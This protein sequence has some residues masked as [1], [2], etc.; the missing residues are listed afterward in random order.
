MRINHLIIGARDA[1]ISADFYCTILDY[2]RSGDF[3]DT[4]TKRT[5]IVLTHA[6]GPELLIVP[7]A[8]ERLPSPQHLAMEVPQILADRIAAA[9]NT[10]GIKLRSQAA[11]DSPNQGSTVI[12]QSGVRYTHFYFCDPSGLNIEIMVRQA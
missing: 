2:H 11:L 8:V 5:G 1:E 6:E 3:V 9:C 10:T 4:G 7:F 12:E